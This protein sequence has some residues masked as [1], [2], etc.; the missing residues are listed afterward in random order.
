[1]TKKRP[2]DQ[3]ENARS[4]GTIITFGKVQILDLGDLAWDKEI[5]LLCPTNKLG[6]VDIFIVSQ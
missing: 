5:E 4:L 6:P 1:M 2:A 3:T